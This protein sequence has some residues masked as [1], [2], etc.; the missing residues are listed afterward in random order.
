MNWNSFYEG[1]YG[2]S[3]AGQKKIA[4]MQKDFGAQEEVA[5]IAMS[6]IDEEVASKFIN[7][8]LTGGVKFGADTLVELADFIDEATLTRALT[9]SDAVFTQE[10]IGSLDGYVSEETI[11]MLNV[12][13][14][15]MDESQTVAVPPRK[16]RKAAAAQVD[17]LTGSP[18]LD[19]F[20]GFKF[21][22]W[23]LGG[24]KKGK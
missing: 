6:F 5:E 3:D 18:L 15:G 4:L 19:L 10:Q 8:A 24:G 21:F 20:I 13:D 2:W 12:I 14:D 16:R 11:E 23:L 7:R 22:D 9:S 17:S 1:F